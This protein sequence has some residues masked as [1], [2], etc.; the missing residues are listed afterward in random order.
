MSDLV[1]TSL[2][3]YLK[4]K[5]DSFPISSKIYDYGTVKSCNS[6]VIIIKGLGRAK[7]GEILEI[8]NGVAYALAFDLK[9]D[10]VG[11]VLLDGEQAVEVGFM[12]KGTG[13][14]ASVGVGE[15]LIGRVIDPLGRP[16]D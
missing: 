9:K 7:Y 2:S 12:V 13:R 8:E 1:Y 15:A 11:A 4:E 14:V 3:A 16:L 5:I 6:D 10:E